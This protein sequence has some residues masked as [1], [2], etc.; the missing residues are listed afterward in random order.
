M[1][2]VVKRRIPVGTVIA[3]RTI[4]DAKSGTRIVV[5]IGAPVFI[6]DGWDW[7]CPYRINGL[8]RTVFGHAHGIDAVQALQLVSLDI[9]HALEQTGRKF[10]WFGHSSW[11]F[12]FPKMVNG[13]GVPA[14]ERHLEEMIEREYERFPADLK[15][16]RK[17]AKSPNS[18]WRIDRRAARP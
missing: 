15:A 13:I 8:G 16:W 12:G 10:T 7:A 3:R 9:R 18:P 4:V 5:S 2:G 6:G 17:R 11:Q 14:F 1:E